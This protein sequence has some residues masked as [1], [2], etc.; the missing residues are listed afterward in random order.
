[1]PED[2]HP[3]GYRIGRVTLDLVNREIHRHGEVLPCG[4][5]TFDMLTLLARHAPG[6]VSRDAL[7]EAVWNGR[8][9]SA[10]TI[11]RRVAL[12]RATLGDRA[13]DPTYIKVVRGQGYALIPDVRALEPKPVVRR[14]RTGYR[15]AACAAL[16]L[17]VVGAEIGFRDGLSPRIPDLQGS[18]SIFVTSVPHDL[19]R[20]ELSFV[21]GTAQAFLDVVNE[22]RLI[23]RLNEVR[24]SGGVLTW[25]SLTVMANARNDDVE[26]IYLTL[27]LIN[28]SHPDYRLSSAHELTSWARALQDGSTPTSDTAGPDETLGQRG[29]LVSRYDVR[30]LPPSEI[31]E[32]S[33]VLVANFSFDRAEVDAYPHAVQS[34]AASSVASAIDAQVARLA[35]H[36][37]GP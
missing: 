4:K 23:E 8:Y 1:M 30:L 13:E 16:L 37:G 20:K 3:T 14:R 22:T 33:Y 5:L 7:V 19:P 17:F 28:G 2:D 27:A 6:V 31:R 11:K 12:L 36:G 35:P 24:A 10:A 21:M 34:D 26:S 29:T 25:D 9:V 18:A 32:G 15:L